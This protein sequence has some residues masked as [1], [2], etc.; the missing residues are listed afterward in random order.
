MGTSLLSGVSVFP[1]SDRQRVMTQRADNSSSC[2]E[3]RKMS[4]RKAM[5]QEAGRQEREPTGCSTTTPPTP[6]VREAGKEAGAACEA[7]KGQARA[8]GIPHFVLLQR[9][10]LGLW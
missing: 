4:T 9:E 3:N 7:P 6:S 1:P 8:S 5:V 2:P 10:T